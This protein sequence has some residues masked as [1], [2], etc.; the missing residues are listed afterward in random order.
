MNEQVAALSREII[1]ES[2]RALD[3]IMEKIF[4][5]DHPGWD[6]LKRLLLEEV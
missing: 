6:D 4:A 2:D 3:A 5:S 1:E